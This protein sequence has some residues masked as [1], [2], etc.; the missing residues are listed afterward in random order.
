MR[1]IVFAAVALSLC[2]AALGLRAQ[3][4]AIQNAG[5]STIS[6]QTTL[7]LVPTLVR[8]KTGSPVFALNASDFALT[9][10][11]V[12]Q[13]LTLD[14]ESGS[15]PLALVV[16]LE[17][18]GAGA[19]EFDELGPLT[20][21]LGS[22]VGNVPHQVAVVAFDSQPEVVQE[23]TWDLDRA[24]GAVAGL[25]ANC[26][27]KRYLDACSEKSSLHHLSDGDNGVAILD[28]LRE[29]VRLLDLMPTGYRR[30]ILLISETVDR[31]SRTTLEEAVRAIGDTNTTIYSVGFST[32]KSEA[33]HYA[34]RELP[35]QPHK[36]TASALKRGEWFEFAN[37]YPSPPH[38]CMG[39][40]SDNDPDMTNN[41]W[42]K[43]YDC[44]GQLAPPLAL[45]K[46]AAIAAR[47]SLQRNVPET[48]AR[49]TGGE[50]FKLTDA[51]SLERDLAAISN[52]LPN[53]YM[54]TYHPQAPH[55]GF[56][57]IALS[58]PDH[59]DLQIIARNS[60][61]IASPETVI[62]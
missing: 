56:H 12:P 42:A 33:A 6:A 46:V 11:G 47:D 5:N 54:L 35:T 52:H 48:V 61:W 1:W 51:K 49:L 18:G 27:R 7:V 21:M 53:R 24:I 20:P 4:S 44:A 58:L 36:L 28:S 17:T 9:D 57:V 30:A 2:A 23:F 19:R 62:P 8:D 3:P 38:G 50:Y 13:K 41:Q 26:K 16:V 40:E 15:Q 32:A 59:V 45:A 22:L 34:Y 29:A 39:K 60:Y 25:T 37:A 14:E 43:F 31:G 55:P 10:D